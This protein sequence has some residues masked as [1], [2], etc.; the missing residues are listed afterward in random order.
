MLNADNQY[1]RTF[2]SLSRKPGKTIT[3]YIKGKRK[4]FFNPVS[5]AILSITLY[6]LLELYIGSELGSPEMNNSPIKEVYDTGYKLGKLIKSNLKFFW[7]FFILCLGISNRMFFHR[8]NLFEHLAGSS[9]V[10]GH[11]TLIGIIGLILLKLPIVF[12][13]LIYFV[14]V[15]LL[16]FSFRNNNFDP[17]R[18]LFSILSTGLAFL[19]FILLPFFFLYLI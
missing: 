3:G 2:I 18:L 12:N 16:Y 19:L 5:Y 11:A 17:L 15:I 7:L 10:V 1:V 13:P 9:Y 8:F 4:P 14:I 6:L